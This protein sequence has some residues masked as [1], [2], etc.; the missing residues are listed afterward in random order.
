MT[1]ENTAFEFGSELSENM[2]LNAKMD[3]YRAYNYLHLKWWIRCFLGPETY[4]YPNVTVALKNLPCEGYILHYWYHTDDNTAFRFWFIVN[5]ENIIP[6]QL[7]LNS[8]LV[9]ILNHQIL[10]AIKMQIPTLNN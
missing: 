8:S 7:K 6:L 3:R 9:Y 10:R 5:C 1:D 2:T 4:E